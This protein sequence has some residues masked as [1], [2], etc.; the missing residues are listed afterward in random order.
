M[1]ITKGINAIRYT[2]SLNAGHLPT[3][4]FVE[5][6]VKRHDF[7]KPE[8]KEYRDTSLAMLTFGGMRVVGAYFRDCLFIT[9]LETTKL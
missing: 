1:I 6:L 2:A 4:D 3:A 7:I 9:E 5:W 8:N